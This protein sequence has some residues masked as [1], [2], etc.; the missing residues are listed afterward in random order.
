MT[1]Q[2]AKEAI[3]RIDSVL[4]D[5]K[6]NRQDHLILTQDVRMIQERVKLSYELEQILS[7]KKD[8]G[9]D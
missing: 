9:T 7:E 1:E 4:R 3:V 6:L 5:T 8:G 2:Q